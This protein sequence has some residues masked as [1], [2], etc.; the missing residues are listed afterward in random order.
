MVVVR[1]E[2][3][4]LG[5]PRG[6]GPR[7]GMALTPERRASGLGGV[8]FLTPKTKT[9][10]SRFCFQDDEEPEVITRDSTMQTNQQTI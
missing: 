4:Y 1:G 5:V 6:A 3:P 7:A 8:R 2:K 10:A 9:A